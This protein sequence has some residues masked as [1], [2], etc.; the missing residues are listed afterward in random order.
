VF[1]SDS[2]NKSAVFK[3]IGTSVNIYYSFETPNKNT[4]QFELTNLG[5]IGWGRHAQ[6]LSKDTSIHFTGVNV[7]DILNIQ[8]N[9]FHNAN[10]DSILHAYTYS[11]K[12]SPYTTLTPA[13][14]KLSYTFK[15]LLKARMQF[16]IQ[17]Y[18]FSNYAP[19][20]MVKVMYQP[21]KRN[22]V[23]LNF[24][25]GGYQSDDITENHNVNTGLELAHDFGKGLIM[26]A[27]TNYLNGY[28][29]QYSQTGQGVY[30]T[31][32]KYFL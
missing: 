18:F 19:L 16:L 8:G 21:T 24:N 26:I 14:L 15:F 5:F 3:G 20:F 31:I 9:V 4:F 13:C 23:S 7:T 25:Y 22:I 30:F 27:G 10:A 12:S 6:Q 17:K 28:L 32:K 1:R 2:S 29:W 11:K